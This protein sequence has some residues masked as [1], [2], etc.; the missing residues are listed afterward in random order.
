MPKERWTV[1]DITITKVVEIEMWAPLDF[2]VQVLPSAS[3]AD[4]ETLTWLHPDYVRDGQIH[5]GVYSFLVET[6]SLK[7]VVDTGAGNAKP[8]TGDMWSM[9][10]TDY[11]TNFRDVWDPADVDAV[12]NTHMHVDHVGWN[13]H[14]IDGQWVPTFTNATHYMIKDEYAHWKRLAD[15]ND[16]MDP[17]LDA[18][19]VFK[20][21]VQPIVDAG[22]SKF[23]EP[24]ASIAPG[25]TLIPSHGHT[26]GHV[27][28]LAEAN[29][30]S[31]VITGDLVH[32]PCQLGHPE[33]SSAYDTDQAAA[34]ATRRG[35][36][37]RFADT[38]TTVIG[39]HFGTPTGFRVQ[40]D[41]AAFR[42]SPEG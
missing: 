14:L 37:E 28:V 22:L 21:S 27:S 31:A 10:D 32:L 33:W 9:L 35:F 34:A 4:V 16:P 2:L 42:L 30:E 19:T 41:G 29:G 11:L 39:T 20:D 1:G 23:V 17:F 13:T 6:P 3:L 26:P 40:R 5:I 25:V 24:D 8:R 12:V 7:L 15:N 18:A 36:L 38:P